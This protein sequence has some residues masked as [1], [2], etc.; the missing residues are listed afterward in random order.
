MTLDPVREK[1]ARF[2]VETGNASE[3][4]RRANPKARKWKAE[5]VNVEA[6]RTKADPTVSLRIE[7]IQAAARERHNIN[8]ETLTEMLREDRDLA[9]QEK[10]SSAAV[11]AVMGLA[12]LHGL[13]VDKAKSE[14]T[15][16]DG[17]PL[18]PVLNVTVTRDQS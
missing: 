2:Y 17:A 9:R 7:E 5:A 3:A 18:V 6:S 13:I 14:V 12:K 1:F 15:G 10:Q 11:S 4:Y 16:K 8:L